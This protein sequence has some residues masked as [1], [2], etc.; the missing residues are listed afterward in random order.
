MSAPLTETGTLPGGVEVDGVLQREFELRLPTVADNI[1]A[2]DEVGSTN[3]V[4]LG[5]AILARQLVRL[6]TLDAKH[7]TF[8]L[9]T[10]MHPADYNVLEEAAGRLEKKRLAAIAAATS[11]RS[12]SD[13]PSAEQA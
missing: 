1:A 13:W 8:D 10:G 4:A 11:T 9:V 12:E 7:I 3:P 5:A 6:G 2:V